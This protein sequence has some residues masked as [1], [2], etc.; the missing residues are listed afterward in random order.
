MYELLSSI[1]SKLTFQSIMYFGIVVQTESRIPFGIANPNFISYIQTLLLIP[2][3]IT[4]YQTLCTE[5]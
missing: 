1:L 4:Q 3:F 2:N 5:Q